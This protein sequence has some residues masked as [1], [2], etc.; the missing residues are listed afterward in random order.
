LSGKVARFAKNVAVMSPL[1]RIG[2]PVFAFAGWRGGLFPSD[3]RSADFLRHYARVFACVEGNS[4]FYGLPSA[5]TV[6]RWAEQAPPEFR[7]SFKFPREITHDR[8]L[9]DVETQ[10]RAFVDC[11]APLGDRAGLP[12]LQLGPDFSVR[13]LAA[14]ERYLRALPSEL[15]VAVE[16]RHPDFFDGQRNE[17]ALHALLERC[18]AERACFDTTAVHAV[19]NGD[20]MTQHSQSRKPKIPRRAI[21][22][23]AQPMTRIVGENSAKQPPALLDFWAERLAEW[24]SEGRTPIVFTHTPD[25]QYCPEFAIALNAKVRE[26]VPKVAPLDV[27]VDIPRQRALF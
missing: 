19:S 21:A 6:A 5:T 14:L 27:A 9:G 17:G 10:T 18:N 15:H 13:D 3:A 24:I 22:L 20:A 2:C 4:T 7:F 16:V 1:I 12:L 23:S 8:K 11:I 26:H 25:D